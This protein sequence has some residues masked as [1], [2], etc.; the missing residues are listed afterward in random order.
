MSKQQCIVT[1]YLDKE[2]KAWLSNQP[3]SFN[4]SKLIRKLLHQEIDATRGNEN[5]NKHR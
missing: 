3:R 2:L 5:G 1:V 4:F